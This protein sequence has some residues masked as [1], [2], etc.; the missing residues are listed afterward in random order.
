MANP[1]NHFWLFIYA[2]GDHMFTL[3]AGCVVTVVLGIIEKRVLKR[4]VSLKVELG[5]LLA[6]LFFACFQ[7]WRDEYQK[8]EKAGSPPTVQVNNQINVPAQGAFISSVDMG[9]AAYKFGKQITLGISCKNLTQST[10]ENVSCVRGLFIVETRLN[11]FKQPIVPEATQ[12]AIFNKFSEDIKS[13]R[14]S[15]LKTLGPGEG[16]FGNAETLET[17]NKRLDREIRSGAKTLLF[18]AEYEWHD[19]TGEHINQSCAWLQSEPNVFAGPG[20]LISGSTE[21]WNRCAHHEGIK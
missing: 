9:L 2:V 15:N 6:F 17:L 8:A 11:R 14:N 20:K 7:A 18:V 10:A 1:F 16:R 12:D 19:S 4:A 3:A 5:I 13:A 21:V